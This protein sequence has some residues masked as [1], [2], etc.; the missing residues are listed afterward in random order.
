MTQGA[1]A[2]KDAKLTLRLPA[3]EL[4]F[5]KKYAREHRLTLTALVHRFF[6]ELQR[7]QADE[8]PRSLTAIAG[9]V[10]SEVDVRDEY[11]RHR[12]RKHR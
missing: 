5:V 3:E 8:V 10:P 2:M 6:L 9:L 12:Q 1:G 11:A 4:E 7:T